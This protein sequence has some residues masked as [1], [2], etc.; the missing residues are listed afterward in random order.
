M[1]THIHTYTRTRIHR[2]VQTYIDIGNANIVVTQNVHF[3]IL[4]L[5]SVYE[6]RVFHSPETPFASGRP[7]DLRVESKRAKRVAFR[8]RFHVLH[9]EKCLR[10]NDRV[11]GVF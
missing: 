1:T 11:R 5:K 4:K 6:T 8:G 7:A 2:Y 10:K 9:G 3:E